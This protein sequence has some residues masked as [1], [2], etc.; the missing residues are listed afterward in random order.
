MFRSRVVLPII[1]AILVFS[2]GC[3]ALSSGDPPTL[4]INNQD[5]T[6]Y[7]LM[8][9]TVSDA[10]DL[11]DVTLRATTESG[12][13]RYVGLADLQSG[14]PY[15]NVTLIESTAESRNL[16]VP[17]TDNVTTEVTEWKSGDVWGYLVE[18]AG[19]E[20][21]V[22]ADAIDCERYGQE[23]RATIADGFRTRWM[24]TCA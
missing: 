11:T 23:V 24:A 8:V 21:L 5:E 9:F 14:A 16:S 3:A 12:E 20:S 6:Q 17:P 2:A 4:T 7:H 18:D 22:A 19:N 13:R 1:L 10:D 15:S